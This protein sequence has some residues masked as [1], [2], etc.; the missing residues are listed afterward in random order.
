LSDLKEIR[1]FKDIQDAII[2]RA[3]MA[4]NSTTRDTVK[5]LINTYYL[6]TAFKK[7]YRW[8]GDTRPLTLK[9]KYE[10]GTVTVTNGSDQITGS[11]TV[12]TEFAH[13]YSKIKIGSVSTPFKVIRVGSNA[14]ITLDAPYTGDSDS[15]VSYTIYQDEYG[16]FPDL[17]NIRKVQIP[18]FSRSFLL[19]IGPDELDRMRYQSPFRTGVPT[20]YTLNGLNIYTAKTWATF[21]INFD[22]WEDDYDVKPRNKNLIIW[23]ALL[24]DSRI[25]QIR[26]TKTVEPMGTDDEEPLIPLE[27]RKV[28]VHGPLDEYFLQQRDLPTHRAWA[29]KHVKDLK[30]M[31]ADIESTDDE[32]ILVVRRD[33]NRRRPQ[34]IFNDDKVLID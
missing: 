20:R 8:S 29:K 33:K 7:A 30:E 17:M 4:D 15:A 24:T 11:S 16:L 21:N 5:E 23:P 10:T 32:L 1:T 9:A 18:G 14:T 34:G 19:P 13:L 28:L 27:N 22:Y 12:W 31:E 25:A 3:K 6:D 26:Y 2:S